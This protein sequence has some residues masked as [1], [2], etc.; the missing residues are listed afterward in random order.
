MGRGP[1]KAFCQRRHS[2]SPT[3]ICKDLHY[4][5]SSVKYKLKKQ[6]DIPSHLSEWLS[7]KTKQTNTHTHKNTPKTENSKGCKR[8]GEFHFC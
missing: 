3:K 2:R 5:S 1:E 7:L 4:Y 8:C 6:W